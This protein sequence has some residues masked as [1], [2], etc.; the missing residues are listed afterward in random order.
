MKERQDRFTVSAIPWIATMGPPLFDGTSLEAPAGPYKRGRTLP[1]KF[2]LHDA[3]GNLISDEEA[4]TIVA[5]LQVF[6]EEPN[7]QGTP[8]DPGEAVPD[9]GDQFRYD[10][11]NDQ[12]IYNLSTKDP[13]WLADYNYGLEILLDGIKVAEIYFS[14]R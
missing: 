3:A 1:V 2:Q 10:A 14:L 7:D 4:A 6:Y 9:I 12:F 13:A 11:D 5:T 8:I